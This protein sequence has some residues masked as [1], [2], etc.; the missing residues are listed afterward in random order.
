MAAMNLMLLGCTYAS[1]ETTSTGVA[2][3][4]SEP[5]NTSGALSLSN[6][7]EMQLYENAQY[8]LELSYPANW[9]VQEPA[10][11]DMGIIVGFLAPGEDV[12][13]PMVYLLLQNEELPAGQEVTLEQYSQAALRNLRVAMPDLE[14]LTENNITIGELPG[15][16]IVYNLESED[17][18]FRVL[19]AW[20][21][22]GE[23]AYVFTYNAPDELYDQFA[24]DAADIIDSFKAGTESQQSENSGLGVEPAAMGSSEE[25]Y[26]LKEENSSGT[27]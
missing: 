17:M 5:L 15:Y 19:K 26:L 12:N 21:V 25:T 18:R 11:N 1:E 10:P 16:A 23:D 8:G 3:A 4:E 9:I 2:P 20:M 14:I 7:Q 24:A 13:N 22:I 6:L 27:Y